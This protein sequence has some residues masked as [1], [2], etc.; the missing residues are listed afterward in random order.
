MPLRLKILLTYATGVALL[1]VGVLWL[2]H[3]FPVWKAPQAPPA[4]TKPATPIPASPASQPAPM[5]PQPASPNTNE[6]GTPQAR[7]EAYIREW[8]AVW[9]KVVEPEMGRGAMAFADMTLMERWQKEIIGVDV[10]H[11][12]PSQ[13]GKSHSAS[14]M[15]YPPDHHVDHEHVTKV[16][17][18]FNSATVTTE[19]KIQ[20][21]SEFYKYK[22]SKENDVWYIVSINHFFSDESEAAFTEAERTAILAKVTSDAKLPE[23]DRGVTPNCDRLFEEGRKVTVLEEEH[24]LHVHSGGKLSVPSGVLGVRDFGYS[25]DE[26]RPLTLRIPPGEYE[27]E[28]SEAYRTVVAARLTLDTS[29]PA[30]SYRPAPALDEESHSVGVDAGNVAIFDAGTFMHLT[31]RKHEEHY[32]DDFLEDVLAPGRSHV[33]PTS[34]H[35]GDPP[36]EKVTCIVVSSGHG[37]GAYPCYWGLDA[38]GKPVSLVVDFLVVAE[39]LKDHCKLPWPP[40]NGTTSLTHPTLA[41]RSMEITLGKDGDRVVFNVKGEGFSK[42]VWRSATGTIV[43]DT[44]DMGLAIEDE[45]ESYLVPK[46]LLKEA[47][48]IEVELHAGIQ[49]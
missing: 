23:L 45:T 24:T 17:G 25:P 3:T 8:F 44:E 27:L 21:S 35:L 22:L 20:S 16:E 36:S 39:F 1:W 47:T 32:Q 41:S 2:R 29:S 30:V 15:G 37:D 38:Q 11:F 14:S 4:A 12:S 49:N 34:I 5:A 13:K 7:V 43:A 31:Q 19:L 46:S 10:R 18:D 33:K 48:E 9:Q 40:A 6:S 42:A 26:M 28:Y